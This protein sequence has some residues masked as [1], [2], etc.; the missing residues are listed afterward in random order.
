MCA[1]AYASDASTSSWVTVPSPLTVA[2]L[3][4]VLP[5]VDPDVEI[6][7]LPPLPKVTALP[8]DDVPDTDL[9]PEEADRRA[10]EQYPLLSKVLP[11]S[12][13][14]T[15]RGA[16][17]QLAQAKFRKELE[18]RDPR[19]LAK[20]DQPFGKENLSQYFVSEAALRH[21]LLP[22]WKSGF[23]AGDAPSWDS[24][25][26]AYYPAMVFRDLLNEYG[27]VDFAPLRGFPDGWDDEKEV[28]LARVHQATA[29]LLHMNG[30]VADLVR[31][32][33]G[34][35]VSAHIS[36]P[37]VSASL[38]KR[39]VP[40]ETASHVTRILKDGIPAHCTVSST[41]ENFK[42]YYFYGNHTTVDQ[43]PE[44]T[45]KAMV[46]DNKR[47]YTLLLDRRSVL[48]M[49]H[50]H[51]TPQGVVDLATPHKNPRPIFDSSFRP[52][53]WCNAIN[54]WTTKDTEPPL[55]FA[56]AEM[57]F[58]VWLYNLRITYP[59]EELYI[60]D[61]DISG[62]F[63]RIK[64]H[65]NCMA[66]H[67]SVQSGFAVINTG[68]T[69]GDN[70]SPSNFDPIALTRRYISQHI[71]EFDSDVI[72]RV[73]PYL[74]AIRM[75]AAPRGTT[76]SPAD[77]D[78]LNPGVIREDGTRMPPP[79]HMHVDDNLYADVGVYLERTV[80]SSVSGL[81]ELLGPPDDPR[82][83]TP[84]SGDKFEATY[85]HQRRLV[86][87][88]FDSRTMTVG[89]LPYK[90]AQLRELFVSWETMRDFDLLEV[91]NLLGILENHTRY[92]RWARCWYLSIQNAVRRALV[93]RY[94]IVKRMY[95]QEKRTRALSALLPPKLE[96]RIDTLISR[97]KARL[98]WHTRQRFAINDEVRLALWHITRLANAS[99]N[100][101][102][103]HLGL[104]IPR[105]PHF[106]SR[107]DAS[108][109]GGGAYCPGLRFWFDIQWGPS[110]VRGAT[111]AKPTDPGFVHINTL[112]F[113]TLVLQFVAVK[114]RFQ[115][116]KPEDLV[117]YLERTTIPSIPVWL[118]ETDNTTSKS[119]EN[120]AT[121]RT[122]QGQ[123]IVAVYSE[124]LRTTQI[125]TI[126]EHVKGVD[127][128]VADDI[129]RVNFSLPPSVRWPQLFARH[130]F[131]GTYDYFQP[132]PE[133]L[134]LLTSQLFSKSKLVPL[135]LPPVL[136][137]FIPA[138]CI[139]SVSVV[140]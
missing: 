58:M 130:P 24:L 75:V 48:L 60:A 5:L 1:E 14:S 64:Y 13:G 8:S 112:E 20:L 12:S 119:W 38:I 6:K 140:L 138:G 47:G 7:R 33:G 83:P 108:H 131:L 84:L 32:I 63:R 139:T 18:R 105:V 19:I 26:D 42:Q 79:Y 73:R 134:Q 66:M 122:P 110:V 102:E 116:S 74:P 85:N 3:A 61:D 67:T 34:P 123:G 96:G 35:H 59:D 99:E 57:G 30:S 128:V 135:E 77:S 28:N 72:D 94:N 82:V 62:A 54:D 4:D 125:H 78:S 51:I 53:V 133:L 118:G 129:S 97:E 86:G 109:Q 41:E 65:P 46:K 68:G 10:L 44:K 31:W 126:C 22:L 27:D 11:A 71:W 103:T 98:I 39:C 17:N 132:S 137:H 69:F 29:A 9:S 113:L 117:S 56:G 91:S 37:Q 21:V 121:A 81:F 95:Q 106:W 88:L 52:L 136:G 104:I 127:N 40:S 50:C 111:R 45:Y 115:S 15:L 25:I 100:P 70:T 43:E 87:R 2:G 23:L 101:W 120:R 55:T 92:A 124:L 89:I 80:F 114:V 76:F 107:G 36:R 49:L 90:L 93:Q 16:F